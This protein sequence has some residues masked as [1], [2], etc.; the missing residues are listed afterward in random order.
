MGSNFFGHD[1]NKLY[2]GKFVVLGGERILW[3]LLL[4]KVWTL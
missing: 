1:F 3:V 2:V 4:L